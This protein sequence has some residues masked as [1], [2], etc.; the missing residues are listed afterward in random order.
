MDEEAGARGQGLSR[1]E[2]IK[3]AGRLGAVAALPTGAIGAV[4]TTTAD[5]AVEAASAL[6]ALSPAEAATLEAVLERLLPSD[7]TGPGAKE[8]NVLRYVDWSLAG[9]LSMFRA[10][11]ATALSALDA[12]ATARFGAAFAALGAAQQDAILSDMEADKATGFTPGSSAVF[13]MI[14]GHA[15]SGHVRGSRARRERRL[16]R[17]EAGALPRAAPDRLGEGADA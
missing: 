9:E 17:L 4:G 3:R 1:A 7:A 11:Y 8:A 13:E 15:L 16:R 5:A 10:P 12:Y 14:R 6:R 2:V